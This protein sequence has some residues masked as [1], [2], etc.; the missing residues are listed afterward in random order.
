[1]GTSFQFLITMRGVVIFLMLVGLAHS[2]VIG[3]V[4]NIDRSLDNSTSSGCETIHGAEPDENCM[5]HVGDMILTQEELLEAY[6]DT[7]RNGINDARYRWPGNSLPYEFDRNDI[8]YGS[9]EEKF[10]KRVIKRFNI[11]L[12]GCLK[13]V[14]RTTESNYVKVGKDPSK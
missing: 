9:N 3:K 5:Y 7:T 1:M 11:D 12:E 2:N 8:G 13:I 4:V 6:G 14:P 10:I